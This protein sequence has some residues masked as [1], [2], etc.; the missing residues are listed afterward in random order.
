MEHH[1]LKDYARYIE[2]LSEFITSCGL[3]STVLFNSHNQLSS[4]SLS[5][6]GSGE[7]EKDG[8]IIVV[9]V[10]YSI[11]PSPLIVITLIAKDD[12]F[13]NETVGEKLIKQRGYSLVSIKNE[14]A[15]YV[16]KK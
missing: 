15:V 12:S 16:V 3:T 11:I 9:Q 4:T 1:L 5:V 10:E 7:F 14:G 2:S 6:I 13:L 8:D